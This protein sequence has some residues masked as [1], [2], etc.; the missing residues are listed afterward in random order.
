[1]E[2]AVF[3]VHSI[4]AELIVEPAIGILRIG[5]QHERSDA[6]IQKA[7]GDRCEQPRA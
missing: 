1:V 2:L 3:V 4:R 6:Q 5:E 7:L